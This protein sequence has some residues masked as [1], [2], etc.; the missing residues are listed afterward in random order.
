MGKSARPMRP[1]APASRAVRGVATRLSIWSL[2]SRHS[3]LGMGVG[4]ATLYDSERPEQA[5]PDPGRGP[6]QRGEARAKLPGTSPQDLSIDLWPLRPR[7]H[8][9]QPA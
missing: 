3:R 8:A 9:C 7:I 1:V 5:G 4:F 2:Y 6:P